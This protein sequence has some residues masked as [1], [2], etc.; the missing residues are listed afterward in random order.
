MSTRSKEK[1]RG[2]FTVHNACRQ[3]PFPYDG[4][5]RGSRQK[6][7]WTPGGNRGLA[8]NIAIALLL[9][10][11]FIV[12]IGAAGAT[13]AGAPPSDESGAENVTQTETAPVVSTDEPGSEVAP[14]TARERGIRGAPTRE[15]FLQ[16]ALGTQGDVRVPAVLFTL[17]LLLA[18][19]AVA[20]RKAR[21]RRRAGLGGEE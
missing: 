14:D 17:T 7:G 8:F 18:V 13:L 4:A 16:H 1:Q 6:A 11:G 10:A 9:C 5:M 15:Q 3:S 20:W 2:V 19:V 12:W 21:A